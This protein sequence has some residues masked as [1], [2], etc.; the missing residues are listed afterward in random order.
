MDV[1]I[2][3]LAG[4]KSERFRED[5]LTYK[6]NGIPLI[7]YPINTCKKL[8][9]NIF[10]STNDPEYSKIKKLGINE[11][12]YIFDD[13]N[14]RCKGSANG[15]ASSLKKIDYDYYIIVPGDAPWIDKLALNNLLNFSIRNNKIVS[16]LISPGIASPHFLA[17]PKSYKSSIMDICNSYSSLISRP[18]NF[19]RGNNT[20]LVGSYYLTDNKKAFHDID[21]KLDILNYN[22]KGFMRR[23]IEI[24]TYI[25]F[26]EGVKSFEEKNISKSYNNFFIEANFYKKHKI[27]NL[28][29]A[30]LLDSIVVYNKEKLSIKKRIEWL[31]NKI[32]REPKES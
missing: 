25:N 10:I 4:G 1:A 27:Y 24:N 7:L 22:L 32:G 13:R 30:A 9:N 21:T 28:E 29:L 17:I 8:S 5:K 3:I 2:I 31:R 23:I 14:F 16:P 20:L 19:L 18:S 15:I 6:L 11:I 12:D 26:R